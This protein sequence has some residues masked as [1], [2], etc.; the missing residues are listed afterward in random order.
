MGSK[1]KAPDWDALY[2]DIQPKVKAAEDAKDGVAFY[3]AIREFTWAFKDGHVG[4]NG[5][6]IEN[7]ILSSVTSSGYGFAVRVL[8]DG[9]VLVSY[10]TAG[11]PAEKAGVQVGDFLTQMGGQSI[12]EALAA[13]EPLSAPFSTNFSE[14][15]QKARYLLRAPVGTETEFVFTK[16]GGKEKTVKIISG[17]ERDS[18]LSTSIYSG[19]DPNAFPVEFKI[20]DS[21]VGYI[22][23]NS[24]YDDLNLI[25]RLFSRALEDFPG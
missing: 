10:V 15:Y 1:G 25:I 23:I 14:I 24:N 21:G 13:V 18:Y 9:N 4:L 22:K 3:L 8:D 20:L 16:T 2:S 17:S 11:G 7:Q 19:S 6:D 5:G 12:K